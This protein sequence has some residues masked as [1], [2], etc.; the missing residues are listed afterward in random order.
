VT[1][2]PERYVLDTSAWLTFIEDEEGADEVELLLE[3]ARA[4]ECIIFTSFMSFMEVYYITCQERDVDEAH[5]RLDLISA[6]P[7]IRA[8]STASL[9]VLAAEIKARYRLSV[10]DAWIA[11]LAKEQG[12]Y[13][14]HKDPEFEPLAA[15]IQLHPLPYKP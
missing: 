8:E 1:S 11:A 7:V 2:T 14:V 6:L 9:G 4:G 10:A 15:C 5:M 13:L 12:A 3:K